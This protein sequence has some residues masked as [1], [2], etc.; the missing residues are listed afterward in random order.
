MCDQ[1]DDVTRED[2][3]RV[4]ID[5]CRGGTWQC[6]LSSEG[7]GLRTTIAQGITPS[8]AF[9]NALKRY[10]QLHIDPSTLHSRRS[11]DE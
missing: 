8:I 6:T 5:P 3:T 2:I 10:K 7:P 9:R 4:V 1:L 11:H